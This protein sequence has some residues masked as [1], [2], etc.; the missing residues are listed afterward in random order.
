MHIGLLWDS[1]S[2]NVGDQAIGVLLKRLLAQ[3]DIPHRVIDPFEPDTRDTSMLVVGGG[4]LIR[5]PGHHFYDAFRVPGP[6]ILNTVGVLDGSQTAYLDEYRMVTVRS[7]P[8]AARLGRG[9]VSPCLTLLY[10]H[11]LPTGDPPVEIPEGAIGLHITV[12]F[13]PYS[14]A[15]VDWLRSAGIGPI[16]WLPVTHYNA[17]YLLMEALAAQVPGSVVLPRMDADDTFRTIGRLRALVSFSL[18]A[19]LFAYTQNVP[20]LV[21]ANS[22]KIRYFLAE[23]NL[24]SWRFETPSDI[25]TLLPRLLDERPEFAARHQ[26]W[27]RCQ[28]VADRIVEHAEDALR[29]PGQRGPFRVP[30]THRGA[31]ETEMGLYKVLTRAC[32]G[33]VEREFALREECGRA[34]AELEQLKSTRSLKL[35]EAWWRF[36]IRLGSLLPGNKRGD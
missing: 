13:F 21:T 17:D 22:E 16:V 8:D 11:H 15:L 36:K 7:E 2:N 12:P 24:D 5:A 25:A 20:F 23:R 26:D 29:A 32:T 4:E 27:Q 1:V 34:A 19:T 9:E 10:D 35:T 3:H 31:Y 18:H 14:A 30:A 6:H 33:A 28:Q